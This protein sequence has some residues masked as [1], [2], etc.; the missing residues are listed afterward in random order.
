[1]KK[2]LYLLPLLL[3]GCIVPSNKIHV[4][5]PNFKGNVYA[6]KNI[7]IK[8]F[9]AESTTNNTFKVSFD[10]WGA[11]N[12]PAVI[13]ASGEAYAKVI[14]ASGNVLATMT[15]AAFKA[16]KTSNGLP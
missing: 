8:G 12:S 4:T 6:A 15:E 14:D 2:L 1:M 3:S 11:T 13:S 16:W 7:V 5:T 10:Y 9:K